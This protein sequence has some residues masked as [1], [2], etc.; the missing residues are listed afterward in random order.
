M[1]CVISVI[2]HMIINAPIFALKLV[3]CNINGKVHANNFR[4]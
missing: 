2:L 3:F 1:S 4:F